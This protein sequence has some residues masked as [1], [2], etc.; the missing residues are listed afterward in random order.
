MFMKT[1]LNPPR[2]AS[3]QTQLCTLLGSLLLALPAWGEEWVDAADF[4]LNDLKPGMDATP[5]FR[6]AMEACIERKAKGLKIPPG[7]W[8]LFPG[9]AFEQNLAVANNDPGI[10]RVVFP[11]DGFDEFT[12]SAE[13]VKFVCH[14]EMIPISAENSKNITLK[15]FSIDWQRPFS[16]QGEVVAV[17]P[18]TNAFDLKLHPEVCY[19]MRGSRFIFLEKPSPTANTWKEWA[20]PVTATLAWEHNLQ[21]N[22]WFQKGTRQPVPDEHMFAM[23]PDPKVE[24]LAPHLIRIFESTKVMPKVGMVVIVSGMLDPNRTSPAIRISGCKDILLEDVTVHHAGG[25]GLIGQRSEN[26]TLR[27][28]KVVLPE[29]K[30]RY[31]TTTADATHFNGCRGDILIE[32]SVFE[33]ML[34]DATNVHGCFVRVEK[35]IGNML[36]CQR[37]HSQQ[38]GLIIAEPGDEVRFVTSADLQGYGDAKVVSVRDLNSDRFEMTVDQLPEGGIKPL[39]GLY[40]LS[41]QANLTFRNSIVRNHRAR[42]MLIATSGKVVVEGNKFQNSSMAGIQMEGDNGFWWESGPTR[43]ALIRN[44]TFTNNAGAV[45]RISAEV[46]ANKFPNAYYHGGIIF[47]N[48]IIETYHGKIVEGQA[49]DGLIFRNNTIRLTDFA[50]PYLPELASFAFNSG[51]NIVL[52]GNSF[53]GSEKVPHLDVHAGTAEALPTMKDNQGISLKK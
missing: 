18:E 7:E 42:T 35:V 38:R 53:V 13:G 24:E 22:M 10:K 29:G 51:R 21:W 27:R 16:L 41:W 9:Y 32:D 37:V 45:L 19:E 30:D 52:E 49:I 20:P 4:G 33:N 44:N 46:D 50:P 48:N 36:I 17:H 3:L 47:E 23:E 28:Y 26:F 34:D 8:H 15:G 6:A 2:S 11:I 14:G 40:N 5:V 12:L 31:V 43:N 25:M 1:H 39:S